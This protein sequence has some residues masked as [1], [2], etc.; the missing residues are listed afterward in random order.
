MSQERHVPLFFIG[1]R[2][3]GFGRRDLVS[4]LLASTGSAT[5][6]AASSV[7]LTS[8]EWHGNHV[9]SAILLVIGVIFP[10]VNVVTVFL[11]LVQW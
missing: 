1:L 3:A 11:L 6:A 5:T 7:T 8:F 10:L 9:G 2:S 4:V